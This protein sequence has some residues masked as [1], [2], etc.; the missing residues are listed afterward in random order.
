M[1]HT[2]LLLDHRREYD[3]IVELRD[4][5]SYYGILVSYYEFDMISGKWNI[6]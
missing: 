6:K 1:D 3:T 4:T 5:A 2:I